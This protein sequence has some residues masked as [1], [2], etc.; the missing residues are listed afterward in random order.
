MIEDIETKLRDRG[1]QRDVSGTWHNPT[2]KPLADLHEHTQLCTVESCGRDA[3]FF[4]SGS[5]CTRDSRADGRRREVTR[6]EDVDRHACTGHYVP[7]LEALVRYA[8]K[9]KGLAAAAPPGTPLED[10][11]VNTWSTERDDVAR[12]RQTA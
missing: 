9:R 11:T 12:A 7:S 4:C 10:E 2:A 3:R 5:Y 6:L 1:W 8:L